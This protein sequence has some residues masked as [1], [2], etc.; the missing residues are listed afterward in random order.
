MTPSFHKGD[1]LLLRVMEGFF[2]CS[3]LGHFQRDSFTNLMLITVFQGIQPKGHWEPRKKVG[4]LS[5][6]EHLLGFEPG[7]FQF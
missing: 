4:S 5:P 3:A 6:D 7:T 2:N 1:C